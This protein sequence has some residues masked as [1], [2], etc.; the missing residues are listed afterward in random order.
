MS[1]FTPARRTLVLGLLLIACAAP[2]RAMPGPAARAWLS[3]LVT[4]IDAADRAG[5][6][7]VS[8]RPIRTVVVHVEIAADGAMQRIEIERSSG[9][10]D[11]DQRALRA[12]RGVG[13]LSAPPVSLLGHTGVADLSIPVE[14]M[15]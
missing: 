15:R 3:D 9:A 10:P 13:P 5:R 7:A 1:S 14:L 12:V 8:G 6:R 2:V 11:L 4:R